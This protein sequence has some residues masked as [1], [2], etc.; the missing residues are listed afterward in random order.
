[1]TPFVTRLALTWRAEGGLTADGGGGATSVVCRCLSCHAIL[2]LLTGR[3]E[4]A[5]PLLTGD[6][7]R[8]LATS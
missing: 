6:G 2:L 3:T 1:M 7:V 8:S 5:A 4:A